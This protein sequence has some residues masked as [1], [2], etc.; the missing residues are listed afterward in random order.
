MLNSAQAGVRGVDGSLYM[1]VPS[2]KP[3]LQHFQFCRIGLSLGIL[4]FS[5]FSKIEGV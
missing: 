3:S 5:F 2:I 4:I 1:T